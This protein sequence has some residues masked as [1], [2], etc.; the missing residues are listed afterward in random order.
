[1]KPTKPAASSAS[2]T[3]CG[4]NGKQTIY[5]MMQLAER[6]TERGGTPRE[7][8]WYKH[9]Y[10][11]RL[12]ERIRHRTDGLR[13]GKLRPDDLT[14]FGTR[15]LLEL[16]QAARPDGLSGQR[17]GRTVRKGG[18]GVAGPDALFWPAHLRRAG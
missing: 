2:R 14:V 16:L 10:L 9:E 12:D 4:L 17:H 11:R 3:S 18:G 13:S 7:P 6:I 5:Q 8:L 1:M 15:A